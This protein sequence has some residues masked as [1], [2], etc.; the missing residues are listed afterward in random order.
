MI[1]KVRQQITYPTGRVETFTAAPISHVVAIQATRGGRWEM[2]A[3]H[4]DKRSADREAAYLAL[5]RFAAVKI[6]PVT[7]VQ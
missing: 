1:A 3:G 5:G 4:G 2:W 7:R 6:L